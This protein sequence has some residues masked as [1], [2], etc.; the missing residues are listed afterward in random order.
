MNMIVN[1]WKCMVERRGKGNDREWKLRA[2]RLILARDR[3][4]RGC[5][6]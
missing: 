4:S 6:K 1:A 5:E 2:K 3:M